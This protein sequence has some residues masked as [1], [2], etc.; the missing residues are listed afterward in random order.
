MTLAMPVSLVVIGTEPLRIG[1][2]GPWLTTG[3]RMPATTGQKLGINAQR[4][5]S[6]MPVE[7]TREPPP[8]E[9]GPCA[10]VS[11]GASDR[12]QAADDREAASADRTISARER[13]AHV[14]D[15]L[16]HAHRREAGL[17]E[18]EREVARA[19]RTAQPL[20]LSFVDVDG[21]KA[22]NDSRGHAAGDQLLRVIANSIRA[23]LRPYDLI[24]RYGGDEFLCALPDMTMA[25]AAER[26]ALVNAHLAVAVGQR[27]DVRR[28]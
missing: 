28:V 3:L 25:E 15:G 11:G 2:R 17:L 18:L 26:F 7:L 9:P 1:T 27:C 22:M 10:T 6:A 23:H 19:N 20:T 5:A 12:T 21:L 24:V 8:T 14:I 13:A 4:P 16:T